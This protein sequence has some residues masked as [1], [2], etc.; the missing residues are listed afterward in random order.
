[1]NS[2]KEV[3]TMKTVIISPYSKP[4]R[5]PQDKQTNPKNYPYWKEVI[6]A[7]RAQGIRT[8]QVGAGGEKPIGADEIKLG[9]SFS[10]LKKLL[11]ASSTWASVDNFFNHFATYHKK[12]GVAIFGRSDPN[13]FGYSE[14]I[15]LLRDRACLREKQFW[16]WEQDTFR[17]DVFVGP[18]IVVNA[19]QSLL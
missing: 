19:I 14:N 18:E 7:L 2:I 16:M 8:I 6:A 1:M 13:I 5:P 4:L 12:R 11:E 17:A 10:D 9:L 15:N 3:L